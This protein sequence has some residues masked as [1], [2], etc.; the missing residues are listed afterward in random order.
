M[1]PLIPRLVSM[2]S[3]SHGPSRLQTLTLRTIPPQIGELS[4]LLRLAPHLVALDIGV[5]PTG[6]LL[7]LIYGEGELTLVPMLQVLF[8]RIPLFTA[9]VQTRIEHLDTLAQVRCELDSNKDSDNT[10][11]PS[12]APGTRT[13][14]TLHTLRYFFDTAKSRDTSQKKLNNWSSS[15]SKEEAKAIDM[16]SR[17]CIRDESFIK[18]ILSCIECCEITN[19]VLRVSL[20]WIA[21]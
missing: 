2:F 15:Y 14:T 19:N 12:L 5:P 21:R 1:G 20:F 3:G 4:T 16:I 10:T 8:M 13:W 6:D 9:G 7:K 11:I 17:W 18:N